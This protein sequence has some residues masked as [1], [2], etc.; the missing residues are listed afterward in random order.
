MGTVYLCH[1][2]M[3]ERI[4]AAVKVIHALET[5]D[6]RQRFVREVEALIAL[7]HPSIV[8]ILGWSNEPGP[9]GTFLA[10]EFV[11]GIVPGGPHRH[12]QDG[13]GARDAIVRRPRR[14]TSSPPPSRSCASSATRAACHS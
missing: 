7:R 2:S 9:N 5:E 14:R 10:M 1:N 4:K 12:G 3:S 8:G 11:H 13:R 6:D